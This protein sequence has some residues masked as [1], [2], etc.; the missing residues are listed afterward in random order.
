MRI[1]ISKQIPKLLLQRNHDPFSRPDPNRRLMPLS[2]QLTVRALPSRT[3]VPCNDGKNR[4]I[5]TSPG[6]TWDILQR[7]RSKAS[8]TTTYLFWESSTRLR[9]LDGCSLVL[10]SCCKLSACYI[11]GMVFPSHSFLTRT[12]G[13]RF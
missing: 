2:S 8:E 1:A 7:R 5:K 9:P 11:Y 10:R 13:I 4:S 12:M 3:I 6:T